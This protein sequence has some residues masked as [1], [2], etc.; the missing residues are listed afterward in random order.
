VQIECLQVQ[1]MSG[2]FSIASQTVLQYFPDVTVQE[3]IGCAHFVAFVL[4]ISFL[5]RRER[6]A[7]TFGLAEY[8]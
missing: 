6:A 1:S 8:N 2:V 7:L 4:S 3:Q 5:L